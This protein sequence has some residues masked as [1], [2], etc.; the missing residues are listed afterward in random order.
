M[1]VRKSTSAEPAR[2]CSGAMKPGVPMMRPLIVLSPVPILSVR[3]E[4]TVV[5]P[6]RIGRPPSSWSESSEGAL[7][8][9]LPASSAEVLT[10]ECPST[11]ASPQSMTTTSPKSPIMMLSGLRSRCTTLR[12]WENATASHVFWK[13]VSRRASGYCSI[14]SCFLRRMSSSASLSTSPFTYFIV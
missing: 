8:S 10:E 1:S 6:V 11:F 3:I 7:S 13:I 14:T 5:S 12:E 4:V 2:A 9:G